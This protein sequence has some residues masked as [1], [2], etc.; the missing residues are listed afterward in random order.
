MEWMRK[1]RFIFEKFII[2]FWNCDDWWFSMQYLLVQNCRL[3]A[4][5]CIS[6]RTIFIYKLLSNI[7]LC[8]SLYKPSY[9]NSKEKTLRFIYSV[10]LCLV[11]PDDYGLCIFPCDRQ[12]FIV[13]NWDFFTSADYWDDEWKWNTVG[14]HDGVF[15][16]A[17]RDL[18][19]HRI[20]GKG[21]L[22]N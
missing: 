9:R 19:P 20:M 14:A 13:F 1:T 15:R 11:L 18:L 3:Q 7:Y 2:H 5:A 6:F 21:R 8:E 17:I 16:S 12:A 22:S 4:N 10:I